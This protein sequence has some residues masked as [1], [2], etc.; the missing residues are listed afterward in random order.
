M[1]GLFGVGAYIAAGQRLIGHAYFM[2]YHAAGQIGKR[3]GQT[4]VIFVVSQH[5]IMNKLR[6]ALPVTRLSLHLASGR[7]RSAH[8]HCIQLSLPGRLVNWRN[9][10]LVTHTQHVLFK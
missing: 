10:C 1:Q 5:D 3:C 7:R 8:A 6:I 2:Q 4:V 9:T